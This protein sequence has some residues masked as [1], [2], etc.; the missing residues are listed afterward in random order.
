[1]TAPSLPYTANAYGPYDSIA[2]EAWAL[3]V[4]SAAQILKNEPVLAPVIR[5]NVL[6]RKDMRAS[7]SSVLSDHSSAEAVSSDEL[8][9]LFASVHAKAPTLIE[10]AAA[11][12]MAVMEF[13]PAAVDIIQPFLFFKGFHAIQTHR[14]AHHLWHD[15]KHNTAL[16]LQSRSSLLYGVD[17]HP[18]AQIGRGIMFDHATG[19]VIGETAVVEDNVNMFHGVTLGGQ[20]KERHD[21][22]PKVRKG[23]LIGAGATVFGNVEIGAGARVAAGSVVLGDVPAGATAAG[24]PAQIV[25]S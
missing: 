18:A 6:E 11:D 17:I 7:L 19:I 10:D 20:G 3:I 14:I 25:R 13:D 4:A 15:G 8:Y 12:L 16:Y 1:M 2:D 21:R 22:H 24:V 5:R 9:R 23:A